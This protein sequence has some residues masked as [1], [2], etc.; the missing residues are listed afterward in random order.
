M[1]DFLKKTYDWGVL[2]GDREAILHRCRLIEAFTFETSVPVH[3]RE[4]TNGLSRFTKKIFRRSLVEYGHLET[5]QLKSLCDYMEHAH[6]WGLVHGD[7]NRKN[8]FT[9][10]TSKLCVSDWE[11]WLTQIVVNRKTPMVTLPFYD[12]IDKSRDNVSMR[13]D[14]V[15]LVCIATGVKPSV[16]DKKQLKCFVDKLICDGDYFS[17][18][19]SYRDVILDT[20]RTEHVRTDYRR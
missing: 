16:L 10:E 17:N 18:M 4:E 5:E 11:P 14:I 3:F 9:D 13:T 1:T 6:S 7:L 8:I 15:C 20:E 19:L 2:C 12:F